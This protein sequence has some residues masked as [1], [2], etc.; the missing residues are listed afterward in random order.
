MQHYNHKT[1]RK[2]VMTQRSSANA[3]ISVGKFCSDNFLGGYIWYMS[4]RMLQPGRHTSVQSGPKLHPRR[5]QRP[6]AFSAQAPQWLVFSSVQ[7]STDLSDFIPRALCSN[8]KECHTVPC[9]ISSDEVRKVEA[10]S[11]Q[12]YLLGVAVRH[13]HFNSELKDIDLGLWDSLSFS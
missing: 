1:Q 11:Q 2:L 8:R 6:S 7:C 3:A 4:R 12:S 9:S 10:R 5:V 13:G